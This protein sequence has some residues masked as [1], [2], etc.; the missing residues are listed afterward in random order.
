M[1]GAA[2][3]QP[4]EECGAALPAEAQEA[5]ERLLVPLPGRFTGTNLGLAAFQLEPAPADAWRAHYADFCLNPW[6]AL[7]Q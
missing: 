4:G 5:P 6:C 2:Q 1:T 3:G 7:G